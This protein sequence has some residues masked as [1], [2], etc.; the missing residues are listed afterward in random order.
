VEYL[1]TGA[2]LEGR[3][4]SLCKVQGQPDIRCEDRWLVLEPEMRS[5]NSEVISR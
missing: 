1:E 2:G 5:V 4:V 3:E